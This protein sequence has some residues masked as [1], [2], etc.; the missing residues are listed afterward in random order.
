MKWKKATRKFVHIHLNWIP[1]TYIKVYD[2]DFGTY[3]A[4]IRNIPA[5]QIYLSHS[6]LSLAPRLSSLSVGV[7]SIY[8]LD[9][10]PGMC[11]E[12][13][14]FLSLLKIH[15]KWIPL[16]WIKVYVTT[17]KIDW[18][19]KMEY[20]SLF[21]LSPMVGITK[22]YPSS[23]LE[24]VLPCNLIISWETKLVTTRSVHRIPPGWY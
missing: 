15:P 13:M 12:N 14:L 21:S 17:L 11:D 18:I 8:P 3:W 20:F 23:L 7:M 4:K 6:T 19:T 24:D 9:T 22:P 16:D 5:M 1:L 2:L 10:Y